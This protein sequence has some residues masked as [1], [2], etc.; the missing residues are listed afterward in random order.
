MATLKRLMLVD[1]DRSA[2]AA[3]GD[4]LGDEGFE[5]ATATGGAAA[6]ELAT[7]FQP[8][9]ALIDL[10][11]PL[12]SGLDVLRGLAGTPVRCIMMTA[13][14]SDTARRQAMQLGAL[15]ILDK[16]LDVGEV[17]TTIRAALARTGN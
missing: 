16:P 5:I 10:H 17:L 9:V 6:L 2:L 7:R 15:E 12:I 14:G 1:D 8:D 13:D 11:M 3:L 4:L